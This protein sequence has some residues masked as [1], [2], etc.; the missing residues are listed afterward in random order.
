MC[1]FVTCWFICWRWGLDRNTSQCWLVMWDTM[2]AISHS[3][4]VWTLTRWLNSWSL[5]SS[6]NIRVVVSLYD[7]VT[8]HQRSILLYTKVL[9]QDPQFLFQFDGIRTMC[10][11]DSR[12]SHCVAEEQ[13]GGRGS[14]RFPTL[15]HY[16]YK[17]YNIFS[18][19]DNEEWGHPRYWTQWLVGQSVSEL[20]SVKIWNRQW[21]FYG[22]TDV[23]IYF[24]YYCYAAAI[25]ILRTWQ[26]K[27]E[28]CPVFIKL[29]TEATRQ[30]VI[31]GND[32]DRYHL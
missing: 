30:T 4:S 24:L 11:T 10:V 14:G 18:S 2:E 21:L 1:F 3:W 27:M 12:L 16:P 31:S 20:N 7:S 9:K 8:L 29:I 22:V 23:C 19:C 26:F 6:Y 28:K 17:Q 25:I 15:A 13:P 5:Y 32:N